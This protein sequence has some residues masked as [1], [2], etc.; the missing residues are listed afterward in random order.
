[1]KET[2]GIIRCRPP[3]GENPLDEGKALP[4]QA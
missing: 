3:I 1:L 2:G 4:R